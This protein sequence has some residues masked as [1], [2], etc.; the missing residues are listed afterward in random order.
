VDKD[1][2]GQQDKVVDKDKIDQQGKVVDKDKIDQ[3]GKVVLTDQRGKVVDKDKIDQRDKVV[4]T[5]T[6][7]QDKVVVLTTIDLAAM[8]HQEKFLKKTLT[9]KSRQ[10][11]L[12]W[13]VAVKK[14]AK[15][16]VVTNVVQC[17]KKKI[18][19]VKQE[20]MANCN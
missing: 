20:K 19:V 15:K 17:V 7:Q 8:L 16:S 11:W 6:V 18:Y 14:L 10:Q 9:I 4:L 5:T 2:I 1:K 3:Q 13:A 12:V